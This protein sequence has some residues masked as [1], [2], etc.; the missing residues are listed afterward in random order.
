MAPTTFHAASFQLV[1]EKFK[2]ALTDKEKSTFQVVT[3]RDLHL[4]IEAIQQEQA[5]ERKLQGMQ[6]LDAFLEGMME[7][8]KVAQ[9]FVNT[10]PILA[11]VW[12]PMK[13]LLQRIGEFI[14]LLSQYEALFQKQP[15]MSRILIMIYED[16]LD[17]HRKAMA[18]FKQR[19]WRKL[20]RA[21]WRTFSTEFS[22]ILRNLRCHRDLIDSQVNVS[23]Y[24][25]LNKTR[26]LVD[27]TVEVARIES[28]Q[29][30]ATVRQWLSAANSQVDQ[31]TYS[32][33]RK[34]YPG[35]CEWLMK[36]DR[37][38]AWFDPDFCST[39]LLWLS[40]KTV[41]ASMVIEKAQE[42]A[43]ISVAFFYC[44]YQ[45]PA[46]NTFLSVARGLLWQLLQQD[47]KLLPFLYEKAS[48]CGQNMLST[49][50]LAKELLETA[51]KNSPKLYLIIDGLDECD[52]EE[53]KTVV[54][55]LE[56]VCESLPTDDADT[57]RC[58]FISQDDNPA[59]K[60]FAKMSSLKVT[61]REL[62]K[63]IRMYA[64]ARS[65][66]IASKFDL[67]QE[68]QKDV[69]DTIAQKAEGAASVDVE[70]Q[71]V[72]WYQD[73]YTVNSK[74]LCGSLVDVH[75]D[76][77]LVLVHHTA[78]RYL[79]DKEHV[80]IA[81]TE[82]SLALLCV[83]YLSLP[84]FD[85]VIPH[86]VIRAR[87]FQGYYCFLEY[88]FAYWGQHVERA[89]LSRKSN[90]EKED[91]ELAEAVDVF[92]DMHWTEP[93][94]VIPTP[95][96]I[97]DALRI[98]ERRQNLSKVASAVHI[99]KRQLH[100]TGKMSAEE[101][102]LSL[103]GTIERVRSTLEDCSL[104]LHNTD[105]FE[106]MYGLDVFRCPRISCTRFYN[107]FPTPTLREDHV[108][109]HERSFFCSFPGCHV[110][111]LGCSTLKELQKHD[112]EAHGIIDMDDDNDFPELPPQKTSF[113]CEKCDATFTRKH[114]LK[115]HMRTHDAPNERKFVCA[116]CGEGFARQGDRTRHQNTHKPGAPTFMCGGELQN[117]APWGCG[118][119]FKRADTL[120]RHYKS[121]KG[122]A[123]KLPLEEEEA[124]EAMSSTPGISI[125]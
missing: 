83:G 41:L 35:T 78:R 52:R 32:N 44:R 97:M 62:E 93:Q 42:V 51:L 80:N 87:V 53:R 90:D 112:N 8:D 113:E 15:Q 67:G 61:G 5:S 72:N 120:S 30:R 54:S 105:M 29:R 7:Y 116:T 58:L 13:F 19:M 55:E 114:N 122:R 110:A 31:D 46:R 70:N 73:K 64:N 48:V 82:R 33:V 91:C 86:S 98:L 43:D 117:G 1:A 26:E 16:L 3:L 106:E 68:K 76:G 81:S 79:T 69:E 37:F 17:F 11:F 14:P 10:T 25:E 21:L 60:D 71:T 59:R 2:A 121:E 34:E 115:I 38:Q 118:T 77:T 88:A 27:K 104:S 75:L 47:E 12:G 94:I 95:R 56:R 45:D 24:S 36:L 20:F 40:G 107:G 74:E 66:E 22:A 108:R 63:D 92:I 23:Q 6:R 84:G 111:I 103:H 49:V 85:Q 65:L 50:V 39:P 101:Q 96:S 119:T 9:I 124:A 109:K 99:T 102:V 18:F 123:C 28:S 89:A 57:L 4:A 125:E 100:A